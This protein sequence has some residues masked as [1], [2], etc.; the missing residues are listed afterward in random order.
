L[1]AGNRGRVG[2]RNVLQFSYIGYPATNY[3]LE[4]AFN[5]AAPS[6][7]V[8][9]QTN[10]MSVSGVLMFTNTPALG[11]NNFWRVSFGAVNPAA[12][13]TAQRSERRLVIHEKNNAR[14]PLGTR[15]RG[16]R[17]LSRAA[18]VPF[19]GC[20]GRRSPGKYPRCDARL[21]GA[22]RRTGGALRSARDG[23]LNDVTD[24]EASRREPS[25]GGQGPGKAGFRIDRQSKH[26][27]MSNGPIK[28]VVPRNN[29]VDAYTMAAIVR[30]AGMT[31]DEF[32]KLL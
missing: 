4:C 18:W 8:G 16:F 7:W 28:V 24:A 31:I 9:Q 20:D 22:L 2:D 30:D 3:A 27:F 23:S 21:P 26:I 29:P 13:L 25:Q 14:H 11:T 10:V 17:E 32:K 5:L 19:A 15:R 12:S 1:A 6:S